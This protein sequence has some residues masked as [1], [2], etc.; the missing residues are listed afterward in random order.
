MSTII[1]LAKYS[2]PVGYNNRRTSEL[3][4][5]YSDENRAYA[6]IA[7]LEG[8]DPE[9]ATSLDNLYVEATS[10]A[11]TVTEAPLAGALAE[12]GRVRLFSFA[13]K[14]PQYTLW[15]SELDAPPTE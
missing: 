10:G 14:L 3:V 5:P 9:D 6:A 2:A 15:L 12:H 1:T 8:V 13:D 7:I 4:G 11:E